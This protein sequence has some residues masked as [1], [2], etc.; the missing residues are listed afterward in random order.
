[1]KIRVSK[2]SISSYSY[3]GRKIVRILETFLGLLNC[4]YFRELSSAYFGAIAH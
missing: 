4:P 2:Q 3:L 1:M